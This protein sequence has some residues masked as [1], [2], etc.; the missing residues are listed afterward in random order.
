MFSPVSGREL[1]KKQVSLWSDHQKAQR[2]PAGEAGEKGEHL[3]RREFRKLWEKNVCL[4]VAE[5]TKG[6]CSM[7]VLPMV[8]MIDVDVKDLVM[9]FR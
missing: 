1:L 3:E 4:S 7:R 9:T 2:I 6:N 8:L 5:K